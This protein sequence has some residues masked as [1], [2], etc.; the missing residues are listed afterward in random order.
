MSQENKGLCKH[1]V[2][3]DK[4][5]VHT[6]RLDIL[7]GFLH[8]YPNQYPGTILSLLIQS[9][10]WN[11][12]KKFYFQIVLQNTHRELQNSTPPYVDWKPV[13]PLD[14]W[15]NSVGQHWGDAIMMEKYDSFTSIT[16][17]K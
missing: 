12:C 9:Q 11:G 7:K 8:S 2:G 17:V 16:A 5:P 10:I 13:D 3:H 15:E 6:F 14:T 4:N 1:I